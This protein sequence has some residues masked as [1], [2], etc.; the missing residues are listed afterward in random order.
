MGASKLINYLN[1]KSLQSNIVG[2]KVKLTTLKPG[3][4]FYMNL[5][6]GVIG[7]LVDTGINATVKWIIHPEKSTRGEWIASGTMVYKYNY[8]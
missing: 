6:H 8:E 4:Y 5:H 2:G 3:D 1:K 7:K